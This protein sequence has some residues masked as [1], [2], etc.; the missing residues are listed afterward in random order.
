LDSFHVLTCLSVCALQLVS[1]P[2][3]FTFCILTPS[4]LYIKAITLQ[5]EL[6]FCQGNCKDSMS[7]RLENEHPNHLR[8][9]PERQVARLNVAF[10]HAR[11][12]TRLSHHTSSASSLCSHFPF[13]PLA[14]RLPFSTRPRT[15]NHTPFHQTAQALGSPKLTADAT[16]AHRTEKATDRCCVHCARP[17]ASRASVRTP[18]SFTISCTILR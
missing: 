4:F 2:C 5:V 3:L 16:S 6:I 18:V 12:Y 11:P 1:A 7:C 10:V 17:L 14:S 8:T 13:F 9:S 15:P